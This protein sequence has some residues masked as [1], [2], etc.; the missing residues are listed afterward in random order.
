MNGD[1]LKSSTVS[2][3]HKYEDPLGVE[4]SGQLTFE[5]AQAH[6]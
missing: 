5:P 1:K 2:E 3:C 6:V 4:S